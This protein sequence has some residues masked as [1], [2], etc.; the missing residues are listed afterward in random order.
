MLTYKVP[1]WVHRAF[2]AATSSNVLMRLFFIEEVYGSAGFVP[3]EEEEAVDTPATTPATE[4]HST[5]TPVA[6]VEAVDEANVEGGEV[7]W[8]LS[9]LQKVLFLVVITGCVATYIRMNKMRGQDTQG[10][11][12]SLA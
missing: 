12:K 2:V 7:T 8:G 9:L 6:A 4:S 1:I 10:Y 3:G 11:E 5:S